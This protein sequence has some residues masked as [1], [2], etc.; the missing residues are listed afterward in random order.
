LRII[1][2]KI[3]GRKI[4]SPPG[5]SLRP[6]SDKV[7]EALFNVLS[8]K[9]LE[10]SVLDLYAGTGAIG[11]EALSRGASHVS[12]VEKNRN[13]L[14][15]LKR[16]LETCLNPGDFSLFGMSALDFLKR[17]KGAYQFVFIDPPYLGGEI[18]LLLPRL[19]QGDMM[20]LGG[21]LV[22]EHFH[23]KKLTEEMGHIYLVKQYKYGETILSFYEKK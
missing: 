14:K 4:F 18:D 11:I 23:K 2:G 19:M 6:T 17:K 5:L 8:E 20:S 9:V 16:N 13:H 15:Y 22:I 12:F 21:L 7:R 10:A 1:A 3:K